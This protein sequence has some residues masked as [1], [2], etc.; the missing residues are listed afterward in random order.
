MYHVSCIPM[1]FNS[2]LTSLVIGRWRKVYYQLAK[3]SLW[4]E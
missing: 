3:L 1:R 2:M 4:K